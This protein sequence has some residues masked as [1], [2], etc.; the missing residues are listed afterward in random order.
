MK[1]KKAKIN[2]LVDMVI[3]IAFLVEAVT[4]FVLWLVLPHGGYQG[5]RNPLYGQTFILSRDGWLSLH[6]WFALVMVLGV[7]IHLVLHRRW[8]YCM[9]RN[10]WREAFPSRPSIPQKAE[11]CI[12]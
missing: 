10:L 9:F 7:V 5:G 4:G 6:D 1:L 12:L 11:E 8:I 3:G 2:L